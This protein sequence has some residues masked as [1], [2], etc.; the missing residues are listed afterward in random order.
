M[1]ADGLPEVHRVVV[2]P[3]EIDP[4]RVPPG[5]PANQAAVGAR[6]RQVDRERQIAGLVRHATRVGDLSLLQQLPPFAGADRL[7]LRA[8]SAPEAQLI[9]ARSRSH[10]DAETARSHFQVELALVAFL[11]L[12]EQRGLIGDQSGE[13]VQPAG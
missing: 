11:H 1:E 8:A 2:A 3:V 12:V 5:A 6:A 13:N 10:H 9:E 4:P 7:G